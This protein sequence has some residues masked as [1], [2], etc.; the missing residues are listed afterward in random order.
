MP[1]WSY[2]EIMIL[3]TEEKINEF[4]KIGL[5]NSNVEPLS[6]MSENVSLLRENAKH[7][8]INNKKIV[9]IDGLAARTF[10]PM[11]DTYLLYDTTNYPNDFPDSVIEEQKQMGAI[12][13]YDY[14]C[15][16]LGTKWDFDLEG[17][18]VKESFT[19]KGIFRICFRCET[20]WSMPTNWLIAINKLVPELKIIITANEESNMF[21]CCGYVKDGEYVEYS[22]YSQEKCNLW[23]EVTAKRD[24][25][26]EET[27]NNPDEVK[28]I[29]EILNI[30]EENEDTARRIRTE[31]EFESE[32]KYPYDDGDIVD[33][34]E[35]DV[36]NVEEMLLE[37]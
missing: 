25:Y 28:R 31:I 16:T 1:N 30:T 17:F 12:G 14:N 27:H 22:D 26:C 4:V 23:E 19:H 13:W 11:P 29:K 37:E 5:K 35:D 3:G 18:D 6:T 9:L 34:I 10:L 15:L 2:N 7:K 36:V 32:E 24:K 20:A 21:N 33:K 8:S